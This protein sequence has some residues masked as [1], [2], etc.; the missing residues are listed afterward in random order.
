MPLTD[1]VV[2]TAVCR[3]CVGVEVFQ[4][5]L[6]A[7]LGSSGRAFLKARGIYT[8]A[9]IVA[10]DMM[11]LNSGLFLRIFFS[12]PSSKSVYAPRSCASSI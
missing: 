9:S 3:I 10:L 6:S 8:H 12:N 1:C 2:F 11:I 4:K 5:V 7:G